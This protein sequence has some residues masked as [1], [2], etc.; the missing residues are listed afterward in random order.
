MLVF[1]IETDEKTLTHEHSQDKFFF[2]M[3]P[4]SLTLD[5]IY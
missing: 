2:I 5:V 4:I 3:I 1:F